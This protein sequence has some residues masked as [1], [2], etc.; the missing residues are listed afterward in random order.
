MSGEEG[1]GRE[2]ELSEEAL[3]AAVMPRYHLYQAVMRALG[4]SLGSEKQS[5]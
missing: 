5:A 3:T 2:T 4:A 1:P